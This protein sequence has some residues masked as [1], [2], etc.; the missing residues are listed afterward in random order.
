[1][2]HSARHALLASMGTTSY[3]RDPAAAL[4]VLKALDRDL[5]ARA[6]TFEYDS[7][8]LAAAADLCFNEGQPPDLACESQSR[9]CRPLNSAAIRA[10]NAYRNELR[11][12][13][14]LFKDVAE[15]LSRIRR[16]HTGAAIILFS[17]G[18]RSRVYRTLETHRET[19]GR[20]FDEVVI[21]PKNPESW[22]AVKDIGRSRL[23]LGN[24]EQAIFMLVGDSMQRDIL[25]GKQA[26]FITIHQPSDFLGRDE[27]NESNTSPD[28]TISGLGEVPGLLASLLA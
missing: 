10:H 9:D 28:Y 23:K 25:P 15:S 4:V 26:G 21:G 11:R 27:P 13:A 1:M 6:G 12:A 18:E 7:R 17:E 22:R 16:D 20:L 5:A 2:F 24:D 14:P 19:C 8:L 3:G